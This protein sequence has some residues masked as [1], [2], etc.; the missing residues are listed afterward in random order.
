MAAKNRAAA[1]RKS[2]F[3]WLSHFRGW[4][5]PQSS[6]DGLNHVNGSEKGVGIVGGKIAIIVTREAGSSESDFGWAHQN[7]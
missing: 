7:L 5:I 2:K 4:R 3:S 1:P 6:L